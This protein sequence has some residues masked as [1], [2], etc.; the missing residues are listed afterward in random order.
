MVNQLKY[1]ARQI[2]T[3]LEW[4]GEVVKRRYQA[5]QENKKLDVMKLAAPPQHREPSLYKKIVKKFRFGNAERIILLLSLIPH[6]AP[7]FLDDIV[8]NL[9]KKQ[10]AQP[11]P[12]HRTGTIPTLDLALF[13][14]AG[15]DLEKRLYFQQLFE[16]DNFLCANNIITLDSE[17]SSITRLQQPLK[18]SPEYLSLLTSGKPY[19]PE[20]SMSFPAKRISTQLKLEDLVLSNDTVEQVKEIRSWVK[21]GPAILKEWQLAKRLSPGLKLLFFGPPG[22]GKTT[23]A[24]VIGKLSGLEVYKIDLSMVIS[25]YVGETQKNLSRVFDA[26]NHKKWIL[27]FDEA[28]AMFAKRAE[29]QNDQNTHY[30]NQ[31][32]A[33]LLQKL[34]DHNGVVILSSNMQKNIDEAFTR[35]FHNMIYFAMPSAGER[36]QIWKKGFSPMT[37]LDKDVDLEQISKNYVISGGAIMNVVRYASLK[38]MER[39]KDLVLLK[40]IVAGI[41]REFQKEGRTI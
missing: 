29:K 12:S 26:A 11:A 4:L 39:K 18:I 7:W 31:E 28:D 8:D 2:E 23:T 38:T 37:R 30:A 36:L 1:N 21:Y 19:Y 35:R 24:S 9:E 17:T 14:L 3:D 27:F 6:T 22:T 25:K 13:I 34:E 32:I 40:D 5:H 33:Y 10:P 41:R 16:Q 15:D 20:F